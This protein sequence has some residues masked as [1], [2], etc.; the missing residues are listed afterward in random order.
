[1]PTSVLTRRKKIF[2]SKPHI[3]TLLQAMQKE[4]SRTKTKKA[5][6]YAGASKNLCSYILAR[7]HCKKMPFWRN[8]LKEQVNS[9][10]TEH[11]TSQR[12]FFNYKHR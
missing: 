12:K 6:I 1:M 3:Y 4:I 7:K 5:K 2:F 9:S 8:A 11:N 10:F